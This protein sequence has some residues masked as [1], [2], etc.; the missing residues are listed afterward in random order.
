MASLLN[1]ASN[2][3]I[4]YGLIAKLELSKKVESGFHSII[5]HMVSAA[6]FKLGYKGTRAD[7][8]NQLRLREIDLEKI[9]DKFK[10]TRQEYEGFEQPLN[11]QEMDRNFEIITKE[12]KE[13]KLLIQAI[14]VE[15]QRRGIILQKAPAPPKTQPPSQQ[16][17]EATEAK[18][19]VDSSQALRKKETAKEMQDKKQTQTSEKKPA[20]LSDKQPFRPTEKKNMKQ[21]DDVPLWMKEHQSNISEF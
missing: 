2:E 5:G 9:L 8:V 14:I 20:S 19:S 11:E 1:L 13:I 12:L 18:Q 6:K 16:K 15:S 7:L 4:A 21:K 10:E 17:P 3:K